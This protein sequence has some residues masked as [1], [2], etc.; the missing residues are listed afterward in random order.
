M[1]KSRKNQEKTPLIESLRLRTYLLERVGIHLG[2]KTGA[3]GEKTQK[4][5]TTDSR[6]LPVHL[7][8]NTV[9]HDI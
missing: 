7:S 9:L 6:L 5:D 3:S 2:A 4:N 8:N 1:K